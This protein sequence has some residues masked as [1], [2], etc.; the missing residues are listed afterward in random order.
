M[1]YIIQN[2][3][4]RILYNDRDFNEQLKKM[5]FPSMRQEHRNPTGSQTSI[6]QTKVHFM[7]KAYSM[8][9]MSLRTFPSELALRN[10]WR[11]IQ[12]ARLHGVTGGETLAPPYLISIYQSLPQTLSSFRHTVI[13]V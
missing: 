8:P 1:T 3:I 6:G 2:R 12:H 10:R 7:T 4:V 9:S 5:L 11:P 13:L